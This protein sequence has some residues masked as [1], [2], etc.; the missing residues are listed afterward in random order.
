MPDRPAHELWV[1]LAG[2]A[3]NVVIAL[4][5]FVVLLL[6]GGSMPLE[7]LAVTSGSFVER[8]MVVNVFLVLFNMIPAFPMD[9]GRVL[10]ALLA[11]RME[12]TRATQIAASFGQG[13][14]LLFGFLGFF[15]NPF[16]LFIAF[17]VWIGAAQEAGVTQLRSALNGIPVAG[18]M[19]TRFRTLTPSD[20][21]GTAVDHLLAGAQVD[22]PV[23]DGGRVVGILTKQDLI[24]ALA[25][26]GTGRPVSEV[27]RTDFRTADSS[28]MLDTAFARLQ[29]CGCRTLP[30]VHGGELVGLLTMENTGEFIAVQSALRGNPPGRRKDLLALA[31]GMSRG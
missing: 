11:A 25:R 24:A 8:L 31:G 2:P 23:A 3:V 26:N 13:F 1:A 7:G 18:A 27:M 5:L 4:L 28:E 29:E 21:L 10:R 17:F 9:G 30:V 16:L 20:S 19:V 12:Y 14:A 22:F 6:T 15:F